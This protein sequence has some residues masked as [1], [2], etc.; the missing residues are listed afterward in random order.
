M[1]YFTCGG[2]SLSNP[3]QIYDLG[4]IYDVPS[5]DNRSPAVQAGVASPSGTGMTY[6]MDARR[7]EPPFKD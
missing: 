6:V 2:Q 3:S 7:V 5:V 4:H 1:R